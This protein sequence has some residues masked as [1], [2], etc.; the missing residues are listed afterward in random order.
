MASHFNRKSGATKER[1]ERQIHMM[2]REDAPGPELAIVHGLYLQCTMRAAIPLT[3]SEPPDFT[4]SSQ[5]L[6]SFMLHVDESCRV[7]GYGR[8]TT[9]KGHSSTGPRLT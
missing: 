2:L 6:G 5:R 7:P 4:P 1:G 9:R 3:T 8:N